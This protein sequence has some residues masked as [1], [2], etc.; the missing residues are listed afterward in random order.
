MSNARDPLAGIDAELRR[1]LAALT[2][3][4]RHALLG[5]TGVRRA[6][7][8]E[9]LGLPWYAYAVGPDP[10]RNELRGHAKGIVAIGDIATGVFAFGGWARGVFAFGGL[11]TGLFSFGG[12]S[13]GLLSAFGGL[14]LSALVAVGG[15][16][17]G[18]LAIGGAAAGH[19]AVGGAPL[20]TYVI[21]P[22]HVDPEAVA[23]FERFGFSLP[24]SLP[25]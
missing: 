4:Q 25:R 23:L 16:A 24:R 2:P 3:A 18:T 20:G 19:Y 14:A 5:V 21:G 17:G 6:S 8:A 10:A 13:V 11:A 7:Q 1:K 9:F 22:E 12:L 15:A